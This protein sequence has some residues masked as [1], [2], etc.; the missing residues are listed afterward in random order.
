MPVMKPA[1][2]AGPCTS[3]RRRGP[4]R[5]WQCLLKGGGYGGKEATRT[6]ASSCSIHSWRKMLELRVR[7]SIICS[8]ARDARSCSVQ[9]ELQGSS[10]LG[11][12]PK[13]QR[14]GKPAGK[15]QP[16]K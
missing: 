9:R 16:D 11:T 4:P 2:T 15:E 6:A 5:S 1:R 13:T 8:A 10:S 14:L 12:E 7:S 3:R